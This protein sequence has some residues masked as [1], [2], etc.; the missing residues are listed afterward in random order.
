MTRLT[1]DFPISRSGG[2]G[3]ARRDDEP[4]HVLVVADLSGGARSRRGAEPGLSG[5][6]LAHLSVDNFEQVMRALQPETTIRVG[7]I[8][9]R[10]VFASMEDFHPDQLYATV[11]ELSAREGTQVSAA[12]E[13]PA[14]PTAANEPSASPSAATGK[15]TE[16]DAST[17]ARLLGARPNSQRSPAAAASAP[18]SAAPATASSAL[19]A[20]IRELVAPHIAR[21][22]TAAASSD[23]SPDAAISDIMRRILHAAPFQQ[24]EAAWRALRWLVC[25]N[26]MGAD[27]HVYVLDATRADLIADLRACRG[28]LE[29]SDLYRLAVRERAASPGGSPFS[30]ILADLACSG[31]EEDVSLFAGLGAVAGQAGGCLLAG[32]DPVLWGAK[33]L[34]N[35]SDRSDWSQVDSETAARMALL[36]GSAVAPFIGLCGPR[37]LGRVPYGPKSDPVDHFDF[38]EL[39]L[40]PTNTD[41]LWLNGAF[42]CA[43]LILDGVVDRGWLAGPGTQLD[44]GDLPHVPL[45]SGGAQPCAEVFLDEHSAEQILRSGI[46]PFM[47][48]RNR[49]AIRL[50]RL[51]S[52]ASPPVQ[53]AF[54]AARS[55]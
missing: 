14:Q 6:R 24:L 32:A 10:L 7:A 16:D 19:D 40:E 26:P 5:A 4:T 30:L 37:V 27:L 31:S 46:M 3:A 21:G 36:R 55:G 9:Q 22:G 49:N 28:E 51:Q 25:E 44:L 54:A 23:A 29:R 50:L 1:F 12:T 41:F 8:E 35:Q 39:T 17:L 2:A 33:D 48:Y 52:I 47:S 53:L 11:R 15:Y 18:R 45:W 43:H 13:S 38:T 20:M 34:P 42:A